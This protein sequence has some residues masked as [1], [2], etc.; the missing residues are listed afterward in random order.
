MG[1]DAITTLTVL[2]DEHRSVS[3]SWHEGRPGVAEADLE[4]AIGWKLRPEGLCRDDLCVPVP[5]PDALSHP[6][7]VDLVAVAEALDR[8]A[9]ADQGMGAVAVG[10]P[11]STR[12]AALRDRQAPDAVL[13]DLDG[14]PHSLAGWTGKKR[15][16]VA[17]SSW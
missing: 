11:A 16:L 1:D 12:R 7:G 5:D 3:G 6:A 13:P 15:L 9:V 4:A 10:V 8:P 2:G 17:F 14:V